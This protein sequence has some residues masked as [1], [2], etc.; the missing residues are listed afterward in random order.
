MKIQMKRTIVALALAGA[1]SS[2][3]A[4]TINLT[5]SSFPYDLGANPTDE[6]AYSVTH[7]PGSFSDIFTFSLTEL[8]NTISSAVALHLPGLGGGDSS[9]QI[10]GG[11]L[12]L[13]HDVEGGA[14][15]SLAT[16]AFGDSNGVLSVNNVAAGSYYWKLDGDAIGTHGGTYQFS[17]NTA[18]VPEP[19][20]YAMMLSGLGLLGFIGR[21][22]MKKPSNVTSTYNYA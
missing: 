19:E 1:F 9:Y 22:R 17:L 12:S 20:T 18:P 3:Q 13:F 6:N 5:G 21:R 16:V 10:T 4:A 7:E 11:Q 8:S 14:D 15:V 2:A